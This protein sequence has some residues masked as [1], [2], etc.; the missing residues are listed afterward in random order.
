MKE[1][2]TELSA[3]LSHKEVELKAAA[4][5]EKE[6]EATIGRLQMALI[7]KDE[8]IWALAMGKELPPDHE[9]S[10]ARDRNTSEPTSS[11]TPPR[12]PAAHNAAPAPDYSSAKLVKATTC[13]CGRAAASAP[14]A[15]PEAAS[16]LRRAVSKGVEAAPADAPAPA[17]LLKRLGSRGDQVLG[18]SRKASLKIDGAAEGQ[19]HKRR[20]SEPMAVAPVNRPS[21]S[22]GRVAGGGCSRRGPVAQAPLRHRHHACPPSDLAGR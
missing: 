12:T 10:W 8:Q 4:E 7:A 9:R 1:L 14:A 15:P 3:L 22:A 13:D 11:A 20:G 2:N 6:L 16:L 19:K 5:R 21:W 17:G 18:G